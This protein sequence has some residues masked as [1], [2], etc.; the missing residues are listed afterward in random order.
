MGEKS[1]HPFRGNQY[2]MKKGGGV[3]A[4]APE[5]WH[6]SEV[7]RRMEDYRKSVQKSS[8]GIMQHKNTPEAMRAK[9]GAAYGKKKEVV[10]ITAEQK[11]KIEAKELS[12]ASERSKAVMRTRAGM[13]FSEM[14]D[15]SKASTRDIDEYN[16][17]KPVIIDVL[18]GTPGEKAAA[19]VLHAQHLLLD[20]R[21]K[22][23]AP[24][25]K[26]T[27]IPSHNPDFNPLTGKPWPKGVTTYGRK[28]EPGLPKKTERSRMV[29]GYKLTGKVLEDYERREAIRKTWKRHP[30]DFGDITED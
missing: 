24:A 8:S 22:A 17:T 2:T 9:Y 30:N 16:K 19:K 7:R 6:T 3:S 27:P 1:G 5:P 15:P 14:K 10:P 11:A 25:P 28:T 18:H 26:K 29:K 12:E 21:K 23:P 4:A 13:P 20:I